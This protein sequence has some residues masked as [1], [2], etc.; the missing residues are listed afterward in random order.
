MVERLTQGMGIDK[1]TFEDGDFASEG[2]GVTTVM[3]HG[4]HCSNRTYLCD[5]LMY[6]RVFLL[7]L[8]K[9]DY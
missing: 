4:K 2:E 3:L 6:E 5:V 9:D 7:L 8:A 1:S